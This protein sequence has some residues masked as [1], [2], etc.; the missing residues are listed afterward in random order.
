M[1]SDTYF[2]TTQDLYLDLSDESCPFFWRNYEFNY[3][4]QWSIQFKSN[5][6][7]RLKGVDSGRWRTLLQPHCPTSTGSIL[8]QLATQGL[9][10][11]KRAPGD[12]SEVGAFIISSLIIFLKNNAE[13]NGPYHR[14]YRIQNYHNQNNQ[15]VLNID[16]LKVL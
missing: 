16:R 3:G 14:M 8:W 5:D 6:V 11:E 9:R 2:H 1:T 10:L 4:I 12:S 13:R 7:P 15:T